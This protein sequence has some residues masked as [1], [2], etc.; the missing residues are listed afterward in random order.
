[1]IPIVIV[2]GLNYVTQSKNLNSTFLCGNVE[3]R[4]V[5][6]FFCDL[7]DWNDVKHQGEICDSNGFYFCLLYPQIFGSNGFY[8]SILYPQI[9]KSHLLECLY[10]EVIVKFC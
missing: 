8:F 6:F 9:C 3:L 7:V 1:M 5:N 2:C 4:K 10:F